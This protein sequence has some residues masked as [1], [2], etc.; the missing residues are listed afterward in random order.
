MTGDSLK[1]QLGVD[2][3]IEVDLMNL[4]MRR[5]Q[6][7]DNEWCVRYGESAWRHYLEPDFAV[8]TK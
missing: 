4:M 6:Q 7:L 8:S 2:G 3:E 1:R 5:F